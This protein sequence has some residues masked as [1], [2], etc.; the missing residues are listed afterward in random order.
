M[1]T[2]CQGHNHLG[3][4]RRFPVVTVV[5]LMA[6]MQ[7]ALRGFLFLY[8]NVTDSLQDSRYKL[9]VVILLCSIWFISYPNNADEV[10]CNVFQLQQEQISK[11]PSLKLIK[12]GD[13]IQFSLRWI[14]SP[15]FALDLDWT[16]TFV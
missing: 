12:Q 7:E 1:T 16:I 4:N 10:K 15:T 11:T 6:C 8:L 2:I 14:H 5:K 3:K 9:E 13:K